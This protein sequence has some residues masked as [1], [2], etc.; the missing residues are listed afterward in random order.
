MSELVWDFGS[1]GEKEEEEYIRVLLSQ[2]CEEN[3]IFKKVFEQDS[4]LNDT[5][6]LIMGAQNKIKNLAHEASVS[7]R[8]IQRGFPIITFF[9]IH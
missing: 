9:L 3:L 2:F 8:D 1:L 6:K 7:Q 5:I 4:Y